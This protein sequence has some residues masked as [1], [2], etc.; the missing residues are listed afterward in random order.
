MLDTLLR[1]LSKG[2]TH[3]ISDLASELGVGEG[4]VHQM[5]EDLVSLGYL[6]PLS[7]SCERACEQ[8]PM[9]GVCS[10]GSDRGQAWQLT[11]KGRRAALGDDHGG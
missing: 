5:I 6:S 2:G 3:S 7:V 9:S 11:E 10:A 1:T 4:M 8:S